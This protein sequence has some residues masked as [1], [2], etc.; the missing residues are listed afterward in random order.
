MRLAAAIAVFL[1]VTAFKTVAQVDEG[2]PESP[3]RA[4]WLKPRMFSDFNRLTGRSPFSLPTAEETAPAAQRY[5]LTGSASIGEALHVFIF[6]KNTQTRLMLTSSDAGGTANALLDLKPGASK[7]EMTAKVRI[8]GQVVD[9]R[10]AEA[11]NT[12]SQAASA[13]QAPPVPQNPAMQPGINPATQQPPTSPR[14]V[15]RRRVISA[16]PGNPNPAAP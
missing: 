6:D 3:D 12:P 8:E 11:P 2:A 1:F 15:I 16:Q 13:T 5:I 10:Y 9:V 7:E 4:P 14:R